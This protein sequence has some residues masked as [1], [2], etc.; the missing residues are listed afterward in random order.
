MSSTW[1]TTRDQ[2]EEGGLPGLGVLRNVISS[3]DLFGIIAVVGVLARQCPGLGM[4]PPQRWPPGRGERQERDGRRRRMRTA[5]GGGRRN[6]GVLQARWERRSADAE[7]GVSTTSSRTRPAASSVTRRVLVGSVVLAVLTALAS[8]LA[9]LTRQEDP[10]PAKT[11]ADS[12]PRPA[13]PAPTSTPL[14]GKPDCCAAPDERSVK[15]ARAAT[16]A[17]WT[18]DTRSFSHA[19]HLSGLRDWMTAEKKYAD[20]KSVTQQVPDRVLRAPDARQR[21]ARERHGR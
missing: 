19:E 13:S 5:A 18:Y 12:V 9:Y 6:G 7:N 3:I 1:P 4:G 8:L 11:T 10:T 2:A 21:P 17:L 15:F 16:K 14:G 20:W